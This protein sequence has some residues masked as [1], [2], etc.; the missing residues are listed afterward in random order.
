MKIARALPR[1]PWL[2]DR[3]ARMA[4]AER[5][6]ANQRGGTLP[7]SLWAL[8]IGA[9]VMGPFLAHLG[10]SLQAGTAAQGDLLKQYSADG[11]IEFVTWKLLYDQTYR[12]SVDQKGGKKVN[13]NPDITV[14]GITTRTSAAAIWIG[15][16]THMADAPFNV[17]GGGALAFDG[18]DYIYALRGG[19]K[20][21]FA[22]Y[23]I[24]GD[25]WVT[26]ANTPENVNVGGALVFTGGDF[27]FTLRGDNKNDFWRY[28]ISGDS[29]TPMA[30]TLANVVDGGALAWDGAD[31]IYALRGDGKKDFTR[32]S[33][34]GNSWET[35]A[36]TPDNVGL[37]GAL[38]FTGGD[39][40]LFALRGDGKKD[41]WGYRIAGAS[42]TPRA[43]TLG[44]VKQGGALAYTGGDYTFAFRGAKKDFWRYQTS[45]D[46]WI[47]VKKAP[48]NV[49]FGGALAYD[50]GIEIYA[51]RGSGKKDFWRFTIPIEDVFEYNL[52]TKAGPKADD[53]KIDARIRISGSTVTVLT[54][55]IIK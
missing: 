20:K 36:N 15:T 3:S 39:L 2:D 46:F 40:E 6:R 4:G 29:W 34:S 41:F 10:T 51:L 37:G 16:W 17:A 44:N 9:L 13:V 53:F 49:E 8:A 7:A 48:D 18:G 1:V 23:S 55:D 25:S 31:Y 12:N 22:R 26:L 5:L 30:D 32:Y 35:R 54:W 14:N 21:D 52:K 47:P 11:S 38:V 24:S 28:S 42:W 50:G 45:L 43:D 19:G 33:I 27:L